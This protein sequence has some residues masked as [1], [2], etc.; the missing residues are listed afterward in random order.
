M[1]SLSKEVKSTT[2]PQT[3]GHFKLLYE[4]V[5]VVIVWLLDIQLHVQSVHITTNVVSSNPTHVRCTRYI[6]MW[7]RLPV[8]CGRSVCS[9][10]SCTNKTDRHDITEILLK[11]A[12]SIIILTPFSDMCYPYYWRFYCDWNNT[13]LFLYFNL[14]LGV[15]L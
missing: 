10:V 8:I 2:Q 3:K 12:L 6:I 14:C 5:V 15:I 11:V 13:V 9:P 7:K 1:W 4:A